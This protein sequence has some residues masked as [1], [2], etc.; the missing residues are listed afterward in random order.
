MTKERYSVLITLFAL[1]VLCP[2][3]SMAQNIPPIAD[4]GLSRYAAQET[5]MLDG[6]GS[7]D[8]DS[9]GPLSYAWRQIDGPSVIMIDANTA[10][11][12][13][14][15]STLI[16]HWALDETEGSVAYDSA[17]DKDGT[18][19]GDPTWQPIAGQIDGALAFDGTDDYVR[20][21]FILDPAAGAFSVFAWIKGGAPG[22]VI[23]SQ[24]DGLNWLSA[25]PAEGNLMTELRF[26]GGRVDE[27]PLLS[28]TL[29]TDANWHC[30]GFVWDGSER[31][32]YVDDVEV[33]KDTQV[34]LGTSEGGLQIGASKNLEPGSFFSGLIDDIRI[35]N[36]VFSTIGDFTQTD[37]IQ[38]C[39]FEL[40]VS[41]GELTSL[42]DT[43]KVIIV[44]DYGSDTLRQEN[45]PFDADKPTVI[46]FGG[47]NCITGRGSWGSTAWAEKANVISFPNG[48]SPDSGGVPRTYY[49]YGDMIIV[50]LSAAAPNYN[51]PIQTSGYSTGGQPAIDVGIHLNL[52]Y[53]DVRYAV[54]RVTFFDATTYCRDY[55]ESITA[56][57]GS[58]VDGEQCWAD[59]YVITTERP[60]WGAN[61]PHYEAAY[62]PF[63]EN[64]LNVWFP[65]ATGN[66]SQRHELAQNWYKR[67]LTNADMNK[68]NNGVVAGAYWSVV[69]P[70]KNLQLAWTPDAQT[71]KLRWYGNW[72]SGYMDFYDESLYPGR[73]PEPVK[74]VG[75]VD[76]GEPYGA[77]LTCEESENAA[78]YQLLFGPDPYRVMDY[79]IISD[80]PAPPHE[81][82][83]TLPFEETWW[84][85][86]VYD[87]YGSTIY[88]DPIYIDASM[89]S[90]PIAGD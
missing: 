3:R 81:V 39:E 8:P 26:I 74:L 67:S 9:S 73:L 37:A 55:S 65:T 10:T 24:T 64:V 4:A 27:P 63:Y 47:G 87:E 17:G 23:I 22:R 72:S 48:Y 6:T 42:P 62:P 54:N 69:G 59:A 53:A 52:S 43:V 16:A 5:V 33:A 29:I 85:V 31:I 11:P 19:N 51:Q 34:G 58:S 44:P 49:K 86:K 77:L 46:Y 84:T 82:I 28:Q 78:G 83:T 61:P 1:L 70:G 90:F 60:G 2:A 80:T 56:F 18:L 75:P 57:L 76:V 32:L 68:F 14:G 66:W 15:G 20:T 41:D 13:I 71:Y 21:P 45:P 38:E 25:G 40:V 35:Y 89:L 30:V 88:A 50:Y 79:Y 7:F 36:R 12:T